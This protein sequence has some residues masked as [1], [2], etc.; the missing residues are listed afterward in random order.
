MPIPTPPSSGKETDTPH[1]L[2]ATG[3]LGAPVGSSDGRSTIGGVFVGDPLGLPGTAPPAD[4]EP[5][6]AGAPGRWPLVRLPFAGGSL[7]RVPEL[8]GAL[9]VVEPV[10]F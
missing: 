5:A 3:T 2:A 10:R 4:L 8:T 9:G 7:V 6:G 1:E